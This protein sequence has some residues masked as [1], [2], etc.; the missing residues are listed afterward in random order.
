MVSG[1]VGRF[2]ESFRGQGLRAVYPARATPG[3]VL[4]EF[5]TD[6][7]TCDEG[8][9]GETMSTVPDGGATRSHPKPRSPRYLGITEGG[10]TRVVD[11][12]IGK[13]SG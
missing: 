7:G 3:Q 13:L 5:T 10:G 4:G 2:K 12:F 6:G 11:T 8:F 9:V 1:V